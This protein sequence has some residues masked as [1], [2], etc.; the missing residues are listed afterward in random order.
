M[1]HFLVCYTDP[2]VLCPYLRDDWSDCY[3]VVHSDSGPRRSV[4]ISGEERNGR[5]EKWRKDEKRRREVEG[6]GK[7][8]KIGDGGERDGDTE[9]IR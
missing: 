4:Q 8:W 6:G 9:T 1:F 5:D 7:L 3:V 2:Y